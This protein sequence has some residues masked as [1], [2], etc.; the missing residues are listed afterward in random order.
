[1]GA[2]G[3]PPSIT[4][5]WLRPGRISCICLVLAELAGC[6]SPMTAW[7]NEPRIPSALWQSA[8]ALPS[9]PL[10]SWVL[11]DRAIALNFDAI[12][13]VRDATARP[14]PA[15]TIEL[16]NGAT[17]EL[18]ITSTVS[19]NNDSSVVRGLVKNRHHGDFIFFITGRVMTGTIHVGERLFKV[20]HISNGRHRLLELNPAELPPD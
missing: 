16:F 18:D 9:V 5:P 19:R 1:M 6:L 10:Q 20:E 11:R 13:I 4:L 15:L 7:T 2:T 14:H 3:M 8:P 12:Q 17:Y